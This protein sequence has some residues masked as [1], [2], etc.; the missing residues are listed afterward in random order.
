MSDPTDSTSAKHSD[1]YTF[2]FT[3]GLCAICA[4]I[5]AGMASG[6]KLK[7][8]EAIEFDRSKQMLTSSGLLNHNGF[9]QVEI[10]PGKWTRASVDT[11]SHLRPNDEANLATQAEIQKFYSDRV[12]AVFTNDKGDLFT[13]EDLH[14]DPAQYF[15]KHQ[16]LGFSQEKYKLLYLILAEDSKD[17]KKDKAFGYIIPV[18]GLG[19]WGPIYGY[20]SIKSDAKTVL[21]ISWYQQ[22]ETPGL[23]A[24]ISESTWQSQFPGKNIFQKDKSGF[25]DYAHSPLG[26]VV[27][28]GK[29]HEVLGE[30]PRSENAVDGM[31]GATITGNG[32]S[33][34][35]KDVLEA[36]R[37]FL[38]RAMKLPT[39]GGK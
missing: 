10:S 22:G 25:V 7:Q 14:I 32:V 21:G 19:L 37:P 4:L 9:F 12:K 18:N 1:S 24:N 6:L 17:P 2:F 3:T 38:L 11:S 26:I 33:K 39:G 27:V 28:K 13:P 29:V 30:D 5:L 20:I 35:Y 36:Y 8:Q 16:K 34:A 23:G 31:S 15:A